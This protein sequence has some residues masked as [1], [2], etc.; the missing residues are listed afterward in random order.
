M[1]LKYFTK[2][3]RKRIEDRL[4]HETDIAGLPTLG[5]GVDKDGMGEICLVEKEDHFEFYLASGNQKLFHKAFQSIKDAVQALV[6]FYRQMDLV[7]KPNKIEK[8]I[9][10]ELGLKRELFSCD[11]C[12]TARFFEKYHESRELTRDELFAIYSLHE[13]LKN[14]DVLLEVDFRAEKY[15]GMDFIF[16]IDDD[17]W[18]VWGPVYGG[19]AIS[20][21]NFDD[22]K[23]ACKLILDRCCLNDS[24]I[25]Q[26]M[27]GFDLILL[28]DK[29][30]NEFAIKMG[31]TKPKEKTR[32]KS[33]FI[34]KTTH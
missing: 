16:K 27:Q 5:Y 10:E 33:L 28:T 2:E 20:P 3:R 26:Y 1:E 9:Y 8:I 29:Q 24:K 13:I 4:L 18:V 15:F 17:S 34:N 23:D 25:D 19:V 6:D 12:D 31:Y 14:E 32:S 30:L 22:V 11:R 21:R 7:D